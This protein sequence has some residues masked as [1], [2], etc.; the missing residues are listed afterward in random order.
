MSGPRPDRGSG[1]ADARPTSASDA[2]EPPLPPGELVSATD[3]R[4]ERDEPPAVIRLLSRLHHADDDPRSAVDARRKLTESGFTPQQI[5]IGMHLTAPDPGERRRWTEVLP[6]LSGI[7]AKPWLLWLSRDP[8]A[9]V[10]LAAVSLMATT[11]DV[12]ML[13]RVR[14]LARDDEDDR[15]RETAQRIGDGADANP[16]R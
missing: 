15:V 10:R 4:T 13:S 11:N 9:Q 1:G 14:E 3:D 16:R 5:E 12:Q 8:D 2:E 7:E 6:R